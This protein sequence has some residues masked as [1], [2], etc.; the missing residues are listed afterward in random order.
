ML[1]TIPMARNR[2]KAWLVA[3]MVG[4]ILIIPPSFV[5]AANT[6]PTNSKLVINIPSCTLSVLADNKIIKTY[7]V[8]VG[9]P[10]AP[11]PL[12]K[13]RIINKIV[14]P[15]WYPPDGSR[16]VPPGPDNPLGRR[17]LGF[18][19]NGYGIH[20][21]NNDSSIGRAVSL[22]CVRMH[23]SD[24]EE[25]FDRV[26]IGTELAITYDTVDIVVDSTS[27][28][29]H[30]VVYPDLYQ[31]G[32]TTISLLEDKLNEL[33]LSD[34]FSPQYLGAIISDQPN[35]APV[36][37]CLGMRV[38]AGGK[39]LVV[40]TITEHN[41]TLLAARPI[42]EALDLPITWDSQKKAVIS[43]SAVLPAHITAG[44][45]FVRLHDLKQQL[46]LYG[47]WHQ[48][49]QILKLF[50]WQ[51]S[52]NGVITA[53]GAWLDEEG[54]WL[55]A[56]SI[57]QAWNE[58]TLVL[59]PA[60]NA[61][62]DQLGTKW[63]GRSVGGELYISADTLTKILPVKVTVLENEQRLDILSRAD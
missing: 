1:S 31:H 61:I 46:R 12:G 62:A 42:L 14:N 3:V 52:I 29:T 35:S 48:K 57:I 45:S 19:P 59:L 40:D 8:A 43:G 44:R 50:T 38:Q 4:M 49:E 18:L 34:R 21:N 41:E 56:D 55:C 7:P 30:L 26:K 63:Y 39:E 17:W 22:G 37:I 33:G 6:I 58:E 23:N 51:A 13:F 36:Y 16:P 9:K 28:Q 10:S 53:G 25:L 5:Y 60:E 24:I 20:G 15:T 2:I 47:F 54:V 32:M 11:T 27:G